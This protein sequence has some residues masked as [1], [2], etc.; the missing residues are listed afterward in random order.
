MT[1]NLVPSEPTLTMRLVVR[2]ALLVI[3]AFVIPTGRAATQDL[4]PSITHHNVK[5]GGSEAAFTATAAALPL[6]DDKG[7][8]QAEIFYVAYT[9][10]DAAR[11]TR[12][13][14]FVFNGGPGASSAP[15]ARS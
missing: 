5:V 9:R 1:A 3:V 2:L 11:E 6:N 12:P 7:E 15:G 8:K 14:T 4:V 10:T 13:I